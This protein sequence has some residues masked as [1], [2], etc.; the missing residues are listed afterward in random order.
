MF[1]KLS[2]NFRFIKCPPSQGN[3]EKLCYFSRLNLMQDLTIIVIIRCYRDD[4]EVCPLLVTDRRFSLDYPAFASNKTD[5]H[6]I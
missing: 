3:I 6:D 2:D 1:R 4:D 5:R